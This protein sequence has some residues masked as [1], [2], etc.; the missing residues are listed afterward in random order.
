MKIMVVRNLMCCSVAGVICVAM[1]SS[2]AACPPTVVGDTEPVNVVLTSQKL[3]SDI[4]VETILDRNQ[5]VILKAGK[6][7]RVIEVRVRP[8]DIKGEEIVV[9][10]D[11]IRIANAQGKTTGNLVLSADGRVNL[12]ARLVDNR[13]KNHIGIVTEAL[14][15][16][17]A[18]HLKVKPEASLLITE[19]LAGAPAVKA[20]LKKHDVITHIGG[21]KGVNLTKLKKL[22]Q[23]YESGQ[24]I[25]LRLLREGKPI[26]LKVIVEEVKPVAK[27]LSTYE[28]YQ[29]RRPALDAIVEFSQPRN[30]ELIATEVR[31]VP[32]LP[33]ISQLSKIILR[34]SAVQKWVTVDPK[35]SNQI[36]QVTP[37]VEATR[38][39]IQLGYIQTSRSESI[40]AQL[41]ASE[42]I[43]AQLR[44]EIA[45]MEQQLAKIK[46]LAAKLAESKE[47]E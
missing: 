30:L 45:A 33:Y 28:K 21:V 36:L 35:I 11:S 4:A 47:K 3:L 8:T 41:R 32:V 20:G 43:E 26:E 29:V 10:A 31:T 24:S 15:L 22:I 16:A 2:A 25:T 19:V 17:L 27:L 5:R 42:S 46:A 37:V 44:A 7:G 1:L 39:Y 13:P 38:R 23:S 12:V 6:D 14:S 40:E 18:G 34:D 9:I